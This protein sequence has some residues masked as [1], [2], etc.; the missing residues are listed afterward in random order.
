M[1]RNLGDSL[2][3]SV[4]DFNITDANDSNINI[5]VNAA[6]AFARSTHQCV[7]I[8]D[9]LRHEFLYISENISSWCGKTSNDIVDLGYKFYVDYVPMKEHTMLQEINE[10]ALDWFNGLPFNERLEYTLSFDFHIVQNNK[11]RLVNHHL[12]P[13]ELTR[14][15]R[16]WIALCTLTM[17]S[18]SCPGSIII[19][20]SKSKFYYEYSLNEHKWM[21]KE[22]ITLNEVEREVL[23][24]SAQGHT[25]N[26][27]ADML[28]KSVDTIKT[29]KRVL[30]SKLGVKNIT[31]AMSYAINNKLL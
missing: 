29:Y 10:N 2:L 31:E 6:K 13:I 9:C 18:K 15:G 26:D 7:Y 12:T 4:S 3:A 28:C 27:I 21:K 24:L 23:I 17:S 22:C 8:I 5:L 19:K 14:D 11:L 20:K 16:L 25:M 1:K 30:F